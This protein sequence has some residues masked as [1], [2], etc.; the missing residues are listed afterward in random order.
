MGLSAPVP[1]QRINPPELEM[2]SREEWYDDF[3]R[4]WRNYQNR[5][6][7][8]KVLIRHDAEDVATRSYNEN[9]GHLRTGEE[10]ARVELLA[11][12]AQIW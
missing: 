8:V 3:E 12:F 11:I 4:Q 7:D 9:D 1:E 5:A 2:E 6:E 10:A